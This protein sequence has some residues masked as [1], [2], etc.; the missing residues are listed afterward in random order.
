MRMGGISLLMRTFR[1]WKEREYMHL[2]HLYMALLT[3]K[4]DC[5]GCISMHLAFG[6]GGGF[7]SSGWIV[8]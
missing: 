8:D 1:W 7:C 2:I 6:L 3:W 4:W 5:E